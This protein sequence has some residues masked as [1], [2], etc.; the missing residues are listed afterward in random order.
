MTEVCGLTKQ[1]RRAALKMATQLINDKMAYRIELAQEALDLQ[2]I[3]LGWRVEYL[4]P[5]DFCTTIKVWHMRKP[6]KKRKA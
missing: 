4:A 2:P 3:E 6:K 1:Q 5:T